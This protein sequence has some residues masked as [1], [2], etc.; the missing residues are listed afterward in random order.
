M[1]EA[2]IAV[3]GGLEVLVN[4]AGISGSTTPVEKSNPDDWEKV[5]QVNLI[6]TF[7]VTRLAIPHLK[8]S[9]AGVIIIMSSGAGR[10]GY[11]NRSAYSATKWA[12]IGF[13]KTLSIELGEFG[14]CG[15]DTHV[16]V[17]H[18]S[19]RGFV[20]RAIGRYLS[21]M[22]E[23]KNAS[24]RS[25]SNNHFT[26]CSFDPSTDSKLSLRSRRDFHPRD[27]RALNR[28]MTQHPPASSLA[29]PC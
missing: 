23:A 21:Y 27:S 10:F 3:L 19:C 17:I 1:V 29:K 28:A 4:N 2:A 20:R 14:K 9:S 16:L 26:D 24:V 25:G 5:V 12:L 7:N 15:S 8:K 6:G 18:Y 22:L 13:T 11:A